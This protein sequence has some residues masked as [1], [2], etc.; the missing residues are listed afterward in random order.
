MD[1]TNSNYLDRIVKKRV[2][3][4]RGEGSGFGKTCGRGGKGQTARTGSGPRLGF[5]GGQTPIFRRFPKRGGRIKTGRSRKIFYQIVNLE[6]LEKD[7]EITNGQEIDF[8]NK[9][10]P[11][12][13]LGEGELTKI[14]TIKAAAFSQS[15]QEKI[16]KVGGKF[17]TKIR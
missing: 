17:Q 12:K 3:K 1:N 11:I 8:T 15:A 2:Q 4:G 13:I 16:T 5:E 6:E 9:K 10:S 7:Q 14:L